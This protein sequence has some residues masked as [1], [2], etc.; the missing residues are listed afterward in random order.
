M[1]ELLKIFRPKDIIYVKCYAECAYIATRWMPELTTEKEEYICTMYLDKERRLLEFD[2]INKG[3]LTEVKFNLM[4]LMERGHKIGANWMAL[5]HNHPGSK[6]PTPS[7]E[8][9][10]ITKIAQAF[11]QEW[12]MTSKVSLVIGSEMAYN[13]EPKFN[14]GINFDNNSRINDIAQNFSGCEIPYIPNYELMKFENFGVCTD[15][16]IKIWDH[17]DLDTTKINRCIEFSPHAKVYK[18]I[19]ELPRLEKNIIAVS[20]KEEKKEGH[21]NQNKAKNLVDIKDSAKQQISENKDVNKEIQTIYKAKG[22]RLSNDGQILQTEIIMI[23]KKRF[24]E[25]YKERYGNNN[26]LVTDF[27]TDEGRMIIRNY[28]NKELGIHVNEVYDKTGKLVSRL[29]NINGHLI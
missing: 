26:Y 11:A 18:S 25:V 6:A 7:N 24:K 3:T 5:V 4:K 27:Y 15:K 23:G 2:C 14:L 17:I 10:F 22:Y 19:L 9:I 12:L 13:V 20:N 8:D 21:S 16:L 1:I 29:E 28:T